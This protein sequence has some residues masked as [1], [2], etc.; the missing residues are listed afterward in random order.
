MVR[1]LVLAL[2]LGFGL[3]GCAVDGGM[4]D[5]DSALSERADQDAVARTA[6]LEG[7]DANTQTDMLTFYRS[8]CALQT[9]YR[10]D[11]RTDE[12]ETGALTPDRYRESA[13]AILATRAAAAD[14]AR[15]AVDGLPIPNVLADEWRSAQGELVALFDGLHQADHARSA[16]MARTD[17]ADTERLRAVARELLS[18]SARQIETENPRIRFIAESLPAS[19]QVRR[20]IAEL[21][22]CRSPS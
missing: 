15:T 7:A 10:A 12:H 8:I 3:V 18:A 6:A 2:A 13:V 16:D 22:E 5:P 20:E 4:V 21:P 17:L 19:K 14:T 9:R 1:A 11:L